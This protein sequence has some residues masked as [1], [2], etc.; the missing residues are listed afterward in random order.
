MEQIS[1]NGEWTLYR[2]Q[3]ANSI[4]ARVPGCVH[5]DLLNAGQIEDPFYRD[6]ETRQ[7]WIGETDWKYERRFT[8]SGAFLAHERVMLRCFGLD[9]LATVEVNGIPVGKA[10]NMYRTWLF[11]VKPQLKTGENVLTICFDAPMPFLRACERER[12]VL[13]AWLGSDRVNSGAWLRKEPCNFGWD[14]GPKLTTSGIWRDIE[15]IA[16]T[17]RLADVAIRQ[18]HASG[19]VALNVQIRVENPAAQALAVRIEVRYDGETVA[20]VEQPVS[21]DQASARMTISQPKLWWIN[22]LG[23][24]PLYEMQVQLVGADDAVL[25]EQSK[26]IGLRTLTLERHADQWGESFYFAI[27]GVPFFAKGANWIPADT[28]VPRL[29][30]DNYTTLIRDAAAAHMNMLRV[31]GGGVY[32]QDAFYDLCDQYGIAIWQDFMFACGT[33]PAFDDAFLA[34]VRVEAEDNVRRLRHHPSLAL[35]CGNNELE[36]GLV[37]AEWTAKTM[38]WADYGRLFDVLLKDVVGAE[39]P[40]RPYWPSSPHTPVGDRADLMNPDSGDTHLWHVWHRREPFEWY[41]TR[42]DRFVS[43]FGFQSFPEPATLEPFIEPEDHNITSYM[44]EYRQRSGIGNSTIIHYLLDWFRLPSSFENGIWLSQILQGMAIKYAVEHW[45]RNM[46]RTMGTIYWQLNDC[47]PAPSWSS[48][49]SLYRWKALHYMAKRFYAPVLISG[50]EDREAGTVAVH[51]T[52]DLLEAGSGVVRW[53]LA[54]TDGAVIEGGTFDA[55]IPPQQ[56]SL[57][58]T[59]SFAGALQQYEA[60]DL[61]IGLALDVNDET[62]SDNLVLFARPKHLSLLDP[63]LRVTV[64]ASSAHHFQVE[65]SAAHPALWAWLATDDGESSFSDNF[66]NLMPGTPRTVEIETKQALSADELRERLLVRSL[67]DTYEE[68]APELHGAAR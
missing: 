3:E 31:W 56:D 59:L 6:N 18:Q 29:T 39:D 23:E 34:N 21:G 1:L 45:R 55:A 66:F 22:G 15:L 37:A 28:F 16:Y 41:R 48:I 51:V 33:Y 64:R 8:V 53:Q 7:F 27:N 19:E 49:N 54:T 10:D 43:E 42:F 35:W 26:R 44:M 50:L 4:V 68:P 20:S 9:T 40:D 14:W 5:L 63:D 60:R 52:S 58:R 65:V 11:D 25:D 32:E 47:W 2:A 36:Q 62:V 17:A 30:A 24:Q 61:L 12:G 38:S 67:F 13:P 57:V 46:P